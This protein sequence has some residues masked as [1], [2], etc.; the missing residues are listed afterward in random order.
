MKRA[1]INGHFDTCCCTG[2]IGDM[3][4][5][6]APPGVSGAPPGGGGGGAA[7]A[8]KPWF[9]P[10]PLPFG[11]PSLEKAPS[12]QGPPSFAPAP[13]IDPAAEAHPTGLDLETEPK[14]FLES[15]PSAAPIPLH[16]ARSQ[17]NG[18]PESQSIVVPITFPAGGKSGEIVIRI[19]L[20]SQD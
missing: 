14:P 18:T 1:R 3:A 7:P 13:A 4:V 10:A 15:K 2:C 9:T 19:V 17:E 11:T 5:S 6:D 16:V 12:F 8:P 20:H